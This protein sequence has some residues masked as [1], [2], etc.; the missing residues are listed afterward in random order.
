[1]SQNIGPS[2]IGLV[3]AG[4]AFPDFVGLR[5]NPAR[6]A[7]EQGSQGVLLSKSSSAGILCSMRNYEACILLGDF[8]GAV[9]PDRLIDNAS[10]KAPITDAAFHTSTRNDRAYDAVMIEQ[11]A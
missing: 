3:A 10:T 11:Q 4:D 2:I 6:Q 7:G 1:L 8:K 5:D 9:G